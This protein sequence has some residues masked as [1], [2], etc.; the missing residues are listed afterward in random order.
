[1]KITAS[2]F[3]KAIGLQGLQAQKEHHHVY[4]NGRD[5]PD[6][7]PEIQAMMDHGIKYEI[8]GICTLVGQIM[9]LLLPPCHAFFEVGCLVSNLETVCNFI[10]VSPDGI[11]E[12]TQGNDTYKHKSIRR[13]KRIMVEVKCPFPQEHLPEEPYY[14]VPTQHVPQLLCQMYFFKSDE[15]WLICVTKKSVTPIIVYFDPVLFQKML[16]I[17][18]DLYGKAKM[19]VPT[20]LHPDLKMLKEDIKKFVTSHCNFVLEVPTFT[21]ETGHI[22]P[23]DIQSPYSAAPLLIETIADCAAIKEC[24]NV[25]ATEC[26]LIFRDTHTCL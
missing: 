20:K 15:L 17:A 4:I 26:R 3:S 13:H 10:A 2:T 22:P 6:I 11:I 1:M 9:P 8:H 5:P 19:T 24:T 12:C 23:T 14:E 7:G 18:K 21:G 16:H 25:L